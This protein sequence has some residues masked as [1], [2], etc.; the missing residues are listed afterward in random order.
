MKFQACVSQEVLDEAIWTHLE[1][2]ASA[3]KLHI[4]PTWFNRGNSIKEL[5]LG[6]HRVRGFSDLRIDLGSIRLRWLN[7]NLTEMRFGDSSLF[8]G[9]PEDISEAWA[10]ALEGV[11][12]CRREFVMAA[13][14]KQLRRMHGEVRQFLIER[15]KEDRLLGSR[16]TT[17]QSSPFVDP[18]RLEQLRLA[19]ADKLDL[20][21]VVRICEELNLCFEAQCFFATGALVRALIDHVPPIFGVSSFHEVANNVGGKSVKASLKHLDTSS[22]NVADGIMHQQI[23]SKEVLSSRTQVDFSHDIDVLLSEIIRKLR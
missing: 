12:G 18:S 10:W 21:K 14:M 22:R 19:R 9:T 4:T 5:R 6:F 17:S 3:N 16:L 15:L 13:A 11:T 23:R 20:A 7:A 2:Y 1:D 8:R